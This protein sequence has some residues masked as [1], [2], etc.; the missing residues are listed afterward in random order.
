MQQIAHRVGVFSAIETLER[1]RSF[2]IIFSVSSP[3][4]STAAASNACS[5]SWP[6]LVRSLW[7]VTQY[8]LTSAVCS[9]GTIKPAE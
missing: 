2:R 1:K 5:D 9:A 4:S 7:Q 6:A 3:C 8:C